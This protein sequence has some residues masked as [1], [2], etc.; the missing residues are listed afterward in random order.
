MKFQGFQKSSNKFAHMKYRSISSSFFLPKNVLWNV[1]IL[2]YLHVSV[3]VQLSEYA[4]QQVKSYWVFAKRLA[5]FQYRENFHCYC[6]YRNRWSNSKAY[7]DAQI[8]LIHET[9]LCE[10]KCENLKLNS[11]PLT[12]WEYLKALRIYDMA[13]SAI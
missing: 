11:T 13:L 7:T 10:I 2:I 4:Y 3:S 5:I 1:C 12:E 6:K 9:Y 8:L